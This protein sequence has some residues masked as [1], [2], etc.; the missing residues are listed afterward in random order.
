MSRA[1]DRFLCSLSS[2]C[3]ALKAAAGTAALLALLGGCAPSTLSTPG[4]APVS[5]H[6][7]VGEASGAKGSKGSNSSSWLA[8]AWQSWQRAQASPPRLLSP[9]PRLALR[10]PAPLQPSLLER[11]ALAPQLSANGGLN[12]FT[13]PGLSGFAPAPRLVLADEASAKSSGAPFADGGGLWGRALR[14]VEAGGEALR[15]SGPGQGAV[16]ST[17]GALQQGARERQSQALRQML[18][19][20]A[21]QRG[22]ARTDQEG[23]LRADLNDDLERVGRLDLDALV[24]ARPSD[25]SLARLANLRLKLLPTLAVAP[26]V[27]RQAEAERRRIETEIRALLREQELARAALLIKLRHEV[28]ARLESQRGQEI[29]RVLEQVSQSDARSIAALLQEQQRRVQADFAAPARLSI[30]GAPAATPA[31]TSGARPRSQIGLARNQLRTF[32]ASSASWPPIA[33]PALPGLSSR[34]GLEPSPAILPAA[35]RRDEAASGAARLP[36]GAQQ[37]RWQELLRK[38]SRAWRVPVR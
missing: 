18:L 36:S 31:A 19:H 9:A 17:W 3:A 28:P 34:H 20:V 38:R 11:L 27:Q 10:A 35:S 22:A 8:Q 6:S 14:Q 33:P 2:P 16:T 25:Q 4:S 12:D 15:W 29:E 37:E 7:A 23:L 5:Q 1:S 26:S 13:E 30:A 24:P 21:Q 32:A